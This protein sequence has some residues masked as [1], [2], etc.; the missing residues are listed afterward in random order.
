VAGILKNER[1]NTKKKQQQQHED[2]KIKKHVYGA[3][4]IKK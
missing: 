3:F 2:A 1:M 4:K